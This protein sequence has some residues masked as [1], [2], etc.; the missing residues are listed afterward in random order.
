MVSGKW[1]SVVPIRTHAHS[2]AIMKYDS[3]NPCTRSLFWHECSQ[4]AGNINHMCD[5]HQFSGWYGSDGFIDTACVPFS[6]WLLIRCA[7]LFIAMLRLPMLAAVFRHPSITSYAN[8]TNYVFIINAAESRRTRRCLLRFWGAHREHAHEFQHL[9]HC[10][11][12]FACS[13]TVW[14]SHQRCFEHDSK[15]TLKGNNTSYM[16]A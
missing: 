7:I 5:D 1:S 2:P 4:L 11:Q 12:T 15:V 9:S 16:T 10:L 14:G 13:T 6:L 3:L 8:N